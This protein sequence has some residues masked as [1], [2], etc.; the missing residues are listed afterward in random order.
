MYGIDAN[1]NDGNVQEH[2]PE[3]N[4]DGGG[5]NHRRTS[6]KSH[7]HGERRHPLATRD[8]LWLQSHEQ[9]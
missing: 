7:R 8:D 6:Q 1:L 4:G 5:R 9:T 2:S 3:P